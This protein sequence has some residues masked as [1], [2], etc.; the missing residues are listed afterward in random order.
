MLINKKR[1]ILSAILD[2]ALYSN[3]IL[4]DEAAKED[5]VEYKLTLSHYSTDSIKAN[6][7]NLRASKSNQTVWLGYYAENSANFDQ[8]RFGYERTDTLPYTKLISSLQIA[9]HG[10]LG[11][12]E[13][14][15]I[16]SPFFVLAGIG[17]TNLR[18]Y[19]NINF[20]PNDAITYGVGW[21]NAED[22][23]IS[24]YAVRDD[25]VNNGQQ[26]AHLVFRQSFQHAQRL[27]LDIFNK[28][29]PNDAMNESI[30][31]T[32]SAITYDIS[33][34]SLRFAYEPKVNFSQENMLRLSAA[35]RF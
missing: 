14:A 15:E 5:K 6:D 33:Q 27:T 29:G 19:N 30:N 25:R 21:R 11:W 2:L 1:L 16:G 20:D 35:F 24:L 34:Y 9:G 7:I 12:S 10:F 3:F 22:T 18:P 26:I 13:N 28:T 4:A 8:L 23:S 32:G 31:A 17:R